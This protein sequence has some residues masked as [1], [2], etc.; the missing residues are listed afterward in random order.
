M[1]RRKF[2]GLVGAA[3]F[4]IAVVLLWELPLFSQEVLHHEHE[5]N[6][7]EPRECLSCHDGVT[8]PGVSTC[9]TK[10]AVGSTSSHPT[11]RPYPPLGKRS[12]F[13]S[14]SQIEAAGIRLTDGQISCVSCH[15]LTNDEK[16]HLVIDNRESRLCLTCHIR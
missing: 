7:D 11:Y 8:A 6:L 13:A 1:G 14:R 16:H 9:T 12:K 15:D 10:C 3:I 4:L 5:V 2:P